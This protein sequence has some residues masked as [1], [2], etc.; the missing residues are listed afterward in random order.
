MCNTRPAHKAKPT[1]LRD[2]VF[3]HNRFRIHWLASACL[4]TLGLSA[5][6]AVPGAGQSSAS[7]ELVF[8]YHSIVPMGADQVRLQPSQQKVDLMASAESSSFEGV[9]R[10]DSS[11][12][13]RLVDAGG[14]PVLYYPDEVCFRLTASTV[15]KLKDEDHPLDIASDQDTNTFLLSLHLR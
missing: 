2:N 9:E 7:S 12:K 8:K 5:T 6:L 15:D 3:W 4:A 13:I 14:S 1:G 11:H 10:R